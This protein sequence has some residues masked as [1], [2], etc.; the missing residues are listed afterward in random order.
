MAYSVYLFSL[1]IWWSMT[2]GEAT[3]C[4]YIHFESA[5]EGAM[6]PLEVAVRTAAATFGGVAVFK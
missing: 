2:W 5:A 3:A 6:K 1:T 4:P